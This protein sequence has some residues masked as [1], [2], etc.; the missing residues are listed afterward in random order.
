MGGS[1]QGK[2]A[3]VAGALGAL[4]LSSPAGI[5]TNFARIGCD[6]VGE[7]QT[8]SFT[9]RD[10]VSVGCTKPASLFT[11]T[12]AGAERLELDA[13]MIISNLVVFSLDVDGQV[14]GTWY[15][16]EDL[17]A[18]DARNG[19]F[20]LFFQGRSNGIPPAANL[21]AAGWRP[22]ATLLFSLD[23]GAQLPG[24]LAV[25]DDDVMAWSGGVF[26]KVWDGQADLGI[27]EG[28][29]LDAL[30]DDGT[31]LYY[32]LDVTVQREEV[33]GRHN[34]MWVYS[35]D[36]AKTALAGDFSIAS[37]QDLVCLDAPTDSD[38][39]GLTDYEEATGL[40]EA[41]TT[42]PGTVY[43]LSPGGYLSGP[44]TA[45]SD[46][47]SFT[48]G[49]EADCGTNPTNR[50]DYLRIVSITRLGKSNEVVRWASANARYYDLQGGTN[51][52]A[53]PA[54]VANNRRAGGAFMAWTNAS[55]TNRYFYR[56]KLEH[57]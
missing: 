30:Y 24:S 45:D 10:V 4:V 34:A 50:D 8:V 35:A 5:S 9:E 37:Q 53:F 33:T 12:G 14:N 6:L 46:G 54:T 47:D 52:K 48:D 43:P 28:A 26:S 44:A 57:P 15:A 56:V 55:G 20:F 18:C 19:A 7:L 22:P 38:G 17:V 11:L 36:T 41:A 32:S 42:V 39:D 29:D 23:T 25:D 51:L 27:P 13:L 1:W 3:V 31:N 21:D 16:D 40:D 49:Q 2:V